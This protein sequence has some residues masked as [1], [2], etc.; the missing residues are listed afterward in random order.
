ML[1]DFLGVVRSHE[2]GNEERRQESVVALAVFFTVFG[3]NCL[4]GQAQEPSPVFRPAL[5]EIQGQTR[6]AIL[7]PSRLPSSIRDRDIKLASGTV[8]EEGYVISL[9][10]SEIGTEATF[11]AGFGGRASSSMIC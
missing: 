8:S 6:L 11:A 9:Y 10:R 3:L 5:E 7:L 4:T 1:A 2:S